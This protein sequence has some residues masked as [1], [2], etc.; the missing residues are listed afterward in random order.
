MARRTAPVALGVALLAVLVIFLSGGGSG[1]GIRAVFAAAIQVRPGQ[2]VRVAGRNVG[3]VSSVQLSGGRAVVGMSIDDGQWPLHVGTTA[4][5]RF[6]AAAAYAMRYVDLRPGPASALP[7]PD[8]ALLPETDT[9]T[10]V[11]FDQIYS[12]FDS[13]TRRHLAGTISGAAQTLSGHGLDLARDFELGGPGIQQTANM[14]GD[15]GMDPAALGTLV[16]SGARTF[17]ALRAHDAQLEGLV[18]NA[19]QTFSVFADNAS[20]MQASIERFPTTMTVSQR[21]LA[22]LDRS[23]G[24]L[25]LLMSNLAPGA[26][27]LLRVAPQITRTLQTIERVGPLAVGTLKIGAQQ[28]PGVTRF[29]KTSTPFLPQLSQTFSRL[30]PMVTCLRP[31]APEIGGYLV[32]WQGG[33]VDAAGHFGRIDIIQTPVPPG[34]SL[35]SAQAVAQAHGALQYAFPR[36]PGLN[37]GKPWLQPQCGAGRNALNPAN[38]PE[39]GR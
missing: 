4:S 23:L 1:H 2:E 18:S 35:T 11:E 15:L 7:L 9:T 26:A 37:A 24:G 36:P 14:L 28:L 34:T 19:A 31:Y 21:S 8:D 38:D 5:L 20:A 27:G 32:T 13:A 6:G 30:V 29:L 33:A 25:N 22:H 12:T 10:P 17:G 16:S 3:S 39:A